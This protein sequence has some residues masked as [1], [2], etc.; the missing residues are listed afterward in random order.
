MVK[1]F[2]KITKNRK[3]IRKNIKNIFLVKENVPKWPKMAK[4]RSTNAQNRPK[5]EN[6]QKGSKKREK[7][8]N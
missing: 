7:I 2:Q 8:N 4:N 6:Y 5:M 3:K 1:K